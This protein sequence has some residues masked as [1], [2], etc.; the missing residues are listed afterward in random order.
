MSARALIL[1]AAALSFGG[2]TAQG[3]DPAGLKAWLRPRATLRSSAWSSTR[4]MDGRGART[5]SVLW[6]DAA[7]RL[8]PTLELRG[9]GWFGAGSALEP[10]DV[11]ASLRELYVHAE[12]GP[13]D[14][15]LGKQIIAWGRTDALNPTDNLSPRDYTLLVPED[16]D[17]KSGTPA[18][19]LAVPVGA[20]TVAAYW[21]AGFEGHTLPRGG[22]PAGLRA[23]EI[24]PEGRAEQGAIRVERSGGAVDWSV[25]WFRGLDLAPDLSLRYVDDLPTLEFRHHRL[26]VLGID[27]AAT[28]GKFGVR[29]EAAWLRTEDTDGR[30]RT[31]KNPSVYAV[32]GADRTW[33]GYLNVNLQYVVR[34]V[35]EFGKG[36]PSGDPYVDGVVALLDRFA[37]Q[38]RELQHGVTLRV[39][40][41]WRQET[42]AADISVV[43]LIEPWQFLVRPSLSYA[44]SDRWKLLAGADLYRGDPG[45]QFHDLEKN[46]L[47]YLELRLGLP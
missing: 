40:D 24:V 1:A 39:A 38:Q 47:G 9:A 45:T 5:E 3:Q 43:T 6:L 14:L 37:Q 29:G 44:L 16:L 41:Q 25:S 36:A 46:S 4:T 30:D 34:W 33:G 32:V 15:R 10:S 22:I 21:L 11:E 12:V 18:A 19:R 13:A 17:Q 7:P 42:V 8:T 20:I 27:A 31:I 23:R 26:E 35:E 28:L 2:G